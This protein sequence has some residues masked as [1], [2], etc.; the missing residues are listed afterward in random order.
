MNAG[1]YKYFLDQKFCINLSV[2]AILNKR[3]NLTTITNNNLSRIEEN[4]KTPYQGACLNLIYKFDFGKKNVRK[5]YRQQAI[6]I[7]ANSD[8][9]IV[10]SSTLIYLSDR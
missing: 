6:V 9:E 2:Y 7:C 5:A 3:R 1:L 4:N 10:N 8:Q